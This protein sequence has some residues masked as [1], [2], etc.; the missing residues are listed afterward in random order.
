MSLLLLKNTKKKDYDKIKHALEHPDEYKDVPPVKTKF[1][2]KEDLKAV[3]GVD[4]DD[5]ILNKWKSLDKG[6]V[7]TLV[8]DYALGKTNGKVFVSHVVEKGVYNG[9]ADKKID[10]VTDTT[11]EKDVWKKNC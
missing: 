10:G 1:E 6:K 9:N 3:L 2:T 7:T 4:V 8:G 5:T 11:D